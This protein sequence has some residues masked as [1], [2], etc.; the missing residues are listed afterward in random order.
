M[1]NPLT[2]SEYKSR[3]KHALGN[4]EPSTG[5]SFL[6]VLNEALRYVFGYANWNWKLRPPALLD[7]VEDQEYVSLPSDFGSGGELLTVHSVW[8]PVTF[9]SKVGLDD[10]A[11][12]RGTPVASYMSFYVAVASPNQTTTAV[13]PAGPR[14]EIWPTPADDVSDA[15][16][17][18]YRAGPATLTSD[19]QIPN[20]PQEFESALTLVARARIMLYEIGSNSPDAVAEFAAAKDELARLMESDGSMEPDAGRMNGGLAAMYACGGGDATPFSSF[21]TLHP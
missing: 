19:S 15:F 7:L 2:V 10:I 5:F 1:A 3:M 8:A 21:P 11:R 16:R 4:A 9:V 14:L 13:R 17:I 18:T 20:I 12:L 6:E